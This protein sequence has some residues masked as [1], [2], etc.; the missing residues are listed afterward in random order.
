MSKQV[1]CTEQHVKASHN[2]AKS[3]F[4]ST[5]SLEFDILSD[6]CG[7]WD[8]ENGIFDL[9]KCDFEIVIFEKWASEKWFL[10]KMRFQKCD[11]C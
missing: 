1:F 5:N 7:K 3:H 4:L 9:K 10:W 6:F 11:L 2:G 8:F